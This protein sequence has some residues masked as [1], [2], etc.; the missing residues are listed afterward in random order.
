V[1]EQLSADL[2]MAFPDMKGFSRDN[3]FRMRQLY[4]GCLEIDRWLQHPTLG[5]KVGT[6]S[7]QI[8][9]SGVLGKKVGTASQQMQTGSGHVL[10]LSEQPASPE[11][12]ALIQHISW[13][14]HTIIMGACERPDERYFYM[15]MSAR[16]RWSVRELRRQIDSA[17]FLR[18][19]SVKRDPEK[20]L[21][22]D[23]EAGD[24][25]PF[26]DHYI[27]EFLGLE[28]EH[29]ERELRR[30][31]LANL[32]QFFLEF[33]RD[34]TLVGEEYPLTID[35]DT[36]R[37]DLLFFHRRLRCLI[38]VDLKI[39]EFLP[40]CVG[41]SLFYVAALDE[42]VRL[43]HE[44]PSIGLILCRSAKQVQVRLALTP[45]AKKIGEIGV[46]T[47]QTALPDEK[48]I[49]QRL[50]DPDSEDDLDCRQTRR[51]IGQHDASRQ[52]RYT[53]VLV[54]LESFVKRDD[55][56]IGGLSKCR[57]IC[58][59]PHVWRKRL[60]LCQASPGGL[61]AFGLFRK[62]D[63]FV[64]YQFIERPPSLGHRNCVASKHFG[65]RYQAQESHLCD[66]AKAT[67]LF[68]RLLHPRFGRGMMNV[69]LKGDCDPEVD[70]RK[71]HSRFALSP[72][73]P[74]RRGFERFV[75]WSDR[76]CR[77]R[78]TETTETRLVSDSSRPESPVSFDKLRP[79]SPL[80]AAIPSCRVQ[81]HR[82]QQYLRFPLHGRLKA[83]FP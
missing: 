28:D 46:A 63:S 82:F 65:I 37:I 34:L 7:R 59:A 80:P 67:T 58:V 6:A 10:S 26:K 40:E 35:G 81:R 77:V 39:G 55:F 16:E 49:R 8:A 75:R 47:C 66:P 48:L 32:R 9:I 21:P 71:V 64:R 68:A 20:C 41:K 61:D 31:I 45:A 15:A 1:V 62:G 50:A 30:A 27:L 38:A 19:M 3:V 12:I 4:L 69:R 22:D 56:E 18:Y 60:M 52:D 79:R 74:P 73:S 36:F 11:V 51:M 44:N 23:A 2:R 54:L 14:Q 33:G 83:R 78:T 53:H 76:G 24:L 17:L 25:L 42:Q 5:G 43:P 70:I 72:R 29:T 57:Q 13:S